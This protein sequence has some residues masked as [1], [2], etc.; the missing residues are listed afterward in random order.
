MKRS[1]LIFLSI[2]FTITSFF[3]S[4]NARAG[5]VFSENFTSAAFQ[6]S[7][8]VPPGAYGGASDLIGWAATGYYNIKNN[9]G[10]T[11]YN[12]A[13]LAR[14]KNGGGAGLLLNEDGGYRSIV[15]SIKLTGLTIGALYDI[16]F[17][18]WGD[19]E[20]GGSY[21]GFVSIN[22]SNLLKYSGK[23]FN[24]GTQLGVTRHAQFYA[25]ETSEIISFG[26]ENSIG[27]AS[28]I[29]SN[30]VISTEIPEPSTLFVLISSLIG[31][32]IFYKCRKSVI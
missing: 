14:Q 4:N 25:N 21:N 18:Q 26:Q 1:G 9:N 19:N 28:P 8:R 30:I 7:L 22:N 5:V 11:F 10:W 31:F 29:I 23:D 32:S 16:S 12:G 3:S 17:L 2:I 13:E 24:A 6:G 27:L 20:P 15:A